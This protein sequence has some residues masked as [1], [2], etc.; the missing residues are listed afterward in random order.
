[1]ASL[2][3]Y[4]ISLVF[5]IVG[6]TVG[7]CSGKREVTGQV[8]VVTNGGENVKLGLV[9]I[10]IVNE[11][12]LAEIAR[13]LVGRAM[14]NKANAMLLKELAVEFEVLVKQAPSGFQSPLEELSK[15][16]TRRA[17]TERLLAESLED[18]LFKNLPPAV[19]QTDADGM[20]TVEL[21]ETEWLAA[22]G[23]RRIGNST[24]NYF[25]LIPTKGAHKKL[26]LSNDRMLAD[27]DAIMLVLQKFSH[28]SMVMRSSEVLLAWAIEKSAAGKKALSESKDA[29]EAE[30]R[31]R[32]R[33]AAEAKATKERAAAEAQAKEEEEVREQ[34]RLTAETKAKAEEAEG[35]LAKSLGLSRPFTLGAKGRIGNIVVCWIPPGQLTVG[36]RNSEEARSSDENSHDVQISRGIFLAETECTQAQWESAMQGNP[37]DFKGADRPVEQVSW[38][39]AME[40]CRKLTAKHRADGRLPEGWEW[41]LPSEAEWEY[42]ARAGTT[43]SRHGELDAVAWFQ[44][45]SKNQTHLVKQKSANAWGLH[46]TLGNVSEWCGDWYDQYPVELVIDPTGPISGT[47]RVIRGGCWKHHAGLARSASRLSFSPN[48]RYSYIGFRPALS[49]IV[50]AGEIKTQLNKGDGPQQMMVKPGSR[51][52]EL[53][54][55]AGR[56]TPDVPYPRDALIRRESGSCEFMIT[57]DDSGGIIDV[58]LMSSSGSSILDTA[59]RRHILRLWRFRPEDVGDWLVPITFSLR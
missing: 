30:L 12:L 56:F 52:L 20:F 36:S 22:R 57:V 54:G 29:A 58:K 28:N 43:S 31:E 32:E 6:W 39:D 15:F 33:L 5:I 42:A 26:L 17:D 19:A 51:R 55:V 59:A 40:F 27:A 48:A 16:V 10:H 41:R 2:S 3:R 23:Q 24:E 44:G 11:R 1:M 47:S 8:F 35:V 21:L 38:I 45:N 49:L 34:K 53:S 46:D 18:A 9:D 13:P 37:S 25:W 50:K 7:G 14:T 4:F